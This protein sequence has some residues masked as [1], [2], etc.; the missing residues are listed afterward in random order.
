M[1]P[2]RK[3]PLRPRSKETTR[4]S[5]RLKTSA[6]ASFT[7]EPKEVY[8][9]F[10]GHNLQINTCKENP[11]ASDKAIHKFHRHYRLPENVHL[12]TFWEIG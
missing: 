4:R 11:L 10:C 5:W 12:D 6:S 2:P 9:D 8:V 1:S 7:F 3:P